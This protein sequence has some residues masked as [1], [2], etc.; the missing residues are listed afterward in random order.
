MD[1]ISSDN[2]ALIRR[3]FDADSST[4]AENVAWHFLS[5]DPELVA[6]FGGRDDA[7]VGGDHVCPLGGS[8]DIRGGPGQH[9]PFGGSGRS[10]VP[11]LA[12]GFTLELDSMVARPSWHSAAACLD[13]PVELF[14]PEQGED[15]QVPV[16]KGSP[17]P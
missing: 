12:D 2:V 15:P 7:L 17:A 16:W 1:S 14:F 13:L 6:H 8:N 10:S 4:L 9:R 3:A 11:G 5:P